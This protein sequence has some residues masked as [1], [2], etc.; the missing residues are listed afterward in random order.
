MNQ[1]LV[2]PNTQE[3]ETA[4]EGSLRPRMLD[5]YIGQ[6]KV[7]ENLRVLVEAARAREEPLDHLLLYGPPGLGKTT[8]AHVVANEMRV[9][10]KITSGPAI[11][12]PGDL[13]AILT[14]LRQGDILFIDEIHRLGKVVEEVL[15]PAMEDFALDIVIGKGPAARSIRL[16]LP[17]FSV[18][19]ATTRLALM[20]SPLRARFGAV[21]RLDFYDE[22]AMRR[23]VARSA[24]IIGVEADKEGVAEIARRSRGTPRVANRLL[25]RVRD[26][27]LVRAEGHITQEVAAQAL[28]L[29]DVD[30][31]GLDDLDRRVL[32]ALV[33][34]FGGGP[35][36]LDTVAA[37]VSEEPDT[38]MDVCEPYLL[39][40]GLI[41]RTPR[42]RVATLLA[43][44]HLGLP[45]PEEQTPPQGQLF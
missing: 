33:T 17:R 4:S 37:S 19:G 26:Y 8:L 27:A 11:E 7:V 35:V 9:S 36:G 22:T 40:K 3:E 1:R 16:S 41:H 12:R 42:G 6:S 38:I 2:S 18:V 31:S 39:Q 44:R 32:R 45:E 25:R 34:K 13:A 43:Y 30:A 20:S 21:Q 10:I 24:Q 14:N 5:E 15:Y 23:I 28:E 29:L